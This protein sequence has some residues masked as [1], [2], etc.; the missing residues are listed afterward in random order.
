MGITL[1]LPAVQDYAVNQNPPHPPTLAP[2]ES[3][4]GF[5]K[6]IKD[7][8]VSRDRDLSI[9]WSTVSQSF[10]QTYHLNLFKVGYFST[11]AAHHHT[12]MMSQT[13]VSGSLASISSF[14]SSLLHLQQQLSLTLKRYT[15]PIRL[16][17][18]MFL[19]ITCL[20]L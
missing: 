3:L 16:Q 20:T 6:C 5:V 8:N 18:S 14:A 9:G 17:L 7:K 13:R 4:S 1:N 10:G 2:V 11:S 19:C 12:G 15:F